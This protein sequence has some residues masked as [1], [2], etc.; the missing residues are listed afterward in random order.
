MLRQH[1]ILFW[2]DYVSCVIP[3]NTG[4]WINVVL[5]LNNCLRR[6]SNIKPTWINGSCL[7][8]RTY[9]A[10]VFIQCWGFISFV[11]EFVFEIVLLL[12]ICFTESIRSRSSAGQSL[13]GWPNID[14]GLA[15]CW[16]IF[17]LENK[18]LT[19]F[20][21]LLHLIITLAQSASVYDTGPALSRCST[22][23]TCRSG[24]TITVF[25]P[26]SPQTQDFWPLM[27]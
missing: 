9:I 6:W 7:V 20:V 4:R 13:W 14:S 25:Q 23:V 15:R 11:F 19:V 8:G 16:W 24:L 1:L 27:V 3:A 12:L 17:L 26:G 5:M 21:C 22:N 18:P 2:T 10:T